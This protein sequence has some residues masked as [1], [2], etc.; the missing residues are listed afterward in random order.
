MRDRIDQ[1]APLR[2]YAWFEMWTGTIMSVYV[3]VLLFAASA[4]LNTESDAQSGGFALV[5]LLLVPILA[6]SSLTTGARER[7]GIRVMPSRKFWIP[8]AL[9]FAAMAALLALSVFDVSYFSWL[10]VVVALSIFVLF[11]AKSVRQLA[12]TPRP[13][14]RMQQ[15][16]MAL[17][18]PVRWNT[19]IMGVFGGLL[20]V[21]AT[22]PILS[23]LVTIAALIGISVS[24]VITASP[25]VLSRAG[26]EWGWIQWS[27]F[28]VTTSTLFALSIIIP[29]SGAHSPAVTAGLGIGVC[30]I[31]LVASALPA[32][33]SGDTDSGAGAGAGAGAEST[34]STP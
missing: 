13:D 29:T 24:L 23:S 11:T 25:W 6:F 31:M 16:H 10:N 2:S 14:N 19:A 32:S 3:G 9:V 28:G 26:F 33:A 5:S 12:R 7:F 20:V 18:R 27:A 21:T 17:S 4:D 8:M 30:L 15:R 1:H 22:T 34:V